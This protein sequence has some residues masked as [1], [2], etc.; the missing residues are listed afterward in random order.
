M[1]AVSR[2]YSFYCKITAHC[3]HCCWAHGTLN[4]CLLQANQPAFGDLPALSQTRDMSLVLEDGS[5]LRAH[6]LYLEHASPVLTSALAC[7]PL[8]EPRTSTD[9]EAPSESGPSHSD[10]EA[11]SEAA[12]RLPLPGV[13]RRQGQLLVTSLY[14]WTRDTWCDGL[15]PPELVEPATTAPKLDCAPLLEL[16]DKAL[17]KSC[18]VTKDL[19]AAAKADVWLTVLDAPAEHELAERLQ[20]TQYKKLVRRFMGSQA[21][22]VDLSRVDEDTVAILEGVRSGRCPSHEEA[23]AQPFLAQPAL[24]ANCVSD[25]VW[26]A[27][28]S[29]LSMVIRTPLRWEGPS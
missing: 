18:G 22:D 16:A 25:G 20:L 28:E 21:H 24:G 12:I 5:S 29:N 15:S 1:H 23:K 9:P 7:R 4:I 27:Y 10:A 3:C 17:V 19:A 6:K 2:S 14:C 11:C 26:Q 13:S 8:A